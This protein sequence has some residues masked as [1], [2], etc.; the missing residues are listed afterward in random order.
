[1]VIARMQVSCASVSSSGNRRGPC[2]QAPPV[3]QCK[4]GERV[5]VVLLFCC[6]GLP[7]V[8]VHVLPRRVLRVRVHD[9]LVHVL[10]P[11]G[12]SASWQVAA[13][14]YSQFTRT[15]LGWWP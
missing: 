3:R 12:R 7:V 2:C 13:R 10:K 5:A 8:Q 15:G 14:H 6:S 11:R 9:D 4:E 1:M